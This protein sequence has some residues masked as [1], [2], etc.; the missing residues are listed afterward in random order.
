MILEAYETVIAGT[1]RT[2]VRFQE[3]WT[4]FQKGNAMELRNYYVTV[5]GQCPAAARAGLP[6]LNPAM[7]VRRGAPARSLNRFDRY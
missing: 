4:E 7:Q 6:D 1:Q 5:Y 2:Q 3:R